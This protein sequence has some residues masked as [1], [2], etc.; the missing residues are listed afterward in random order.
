MVNLVL[1]N[2]QKMTILTLQ[3]TKKFTKTANLI[4]VLIALAIHI[5]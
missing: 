2:N 1:K 4:N 5:Y 3:M